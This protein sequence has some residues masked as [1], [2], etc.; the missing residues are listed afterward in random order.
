M[1]LVAVDDRP[2][3]S[4]PFTEKG[5]ILLHWQGSVSTVERIDQ[6]TF[7]IH[8]PVLARAHES[9]GK[10]VACE[11]VLEGADQRLGIKFRVREL[12]GDRVLCGFYDL[13]IATREKLA[14]LIERSST[15]QSD[16]L[17]SLT[18]DELALGKTDRAE[19]EASAEALSTST[20]TLK[21]AIVTTVL[22]ASMLLAA[23]WVVSMVRSQS[24]IAVSNSVMV[25]NYQPI[26]TPLEG[27]LS[28]LRV[29]VGDRVKPGQVLA[30]VAKPDMEH[31]LRAAD[32][33]VARAERDLET[34]Q[35]Q[36]REVEQMLTIARLSLSNKREIELATKRRIET[37][38]EAASKQH[39]RLG[40]LLARKHVKAADYENAEALKR[41]LEAEL[42]RQEAL[43]SGIALAES[44][45]AEGVIVD[46]AR[47]TSPLSD[48]EA[49]IALARSKV[50]ELRSDRDS[51][52]A[53]A[54]PTELIAPSSGTV[55]AVYRR[56]GEVLKHAEEAVALSR[57]GDSWATGHISS[58]LAAQVKP[59]QAVEIEIPSFGLSTTG[60]VE[61]IGHRAVHGRG[62]YTADF[63]GSPLDVPIR[64][65]INHTGESI[66]SGLRLNM[67]IRLR[68]YAQD[69]RDWIGEWQDSI[70][71]LFDGLAWPSS[72]TSASAKNS[73]SP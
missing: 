41:R 52:A 60:I 70:A 25:G 64:V 30:T 55:L 44:A 72:I 68:D 18:Y 27:R 17:H 62:G 28:E 11:G 32:A 21:K 4:D 36:G 37:D 69:L 19:P 1:V 58:S 67:T 39:A 53:K 38:L 16:A 63:R 73:P 33:E 35:R 7:V 71:R 57:D 15:S 61:G 2:D 51:L 50:E 40:R 46:N 47:L 66:P 31:E 26:S 20:S 49:K 29:A 3:Q 59:G 12:D 6:F 22:A 34:Y 23:V 54:K 48:I 14:R 13:P 45:A 42:K 10:A 5:A 24:T 43:I 9:V 8:A 56:P 65:A